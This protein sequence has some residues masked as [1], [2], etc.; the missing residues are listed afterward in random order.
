M[1]DLELRRISVSA[2]HHGE[3]MRN[4]KGNTTFAFAVNQWLETPSR[5]GRDKGKKDHGYG[6]F[7]KK[8]WG[9]KQIEDVK[10][11]DV[12]KMIS[13]LRS[14][15]V[16]NG[17]RMS[18][19]GVNNY[20]SVYNAVMNFSV[21]ELK[22]VRNFP[23][24]SKRKE[25]RREYFPQPEVISRMHDELISMGGQ[26]TL[27]AEMLLFCWHTQLRNTNVTNLK[28]SQVSGDLSFITIESHHMKNGLP[29][30]RPLNSDARAII[31]RNIERGYALQQ[32]F[33]WL[34]PIEYVFVQD[35]GRSIGKPFG[36]SGL[37]NQQWRL[38]RERAGIPSEFVFHS[39]RHGAAST[40]RREGVSLPVISTLMGHSDMKSTL[41][42]QHVT[43]NESREASDITA[44]FSI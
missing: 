33:S 7:F 31:E 18:E 24:W 43:S 26:N 36:R 39:I 38:A 44:S 29:F 21:N 12:D 19:G 30:E 17:R 8:A 11:R 14:K 3:V 13:S 10:E 40:L 27:R 22:I 37:V 41:I 20:A 5:N 28:I 15:T 1:I 42:Y 34:D 6:E 23:K 4:R 16:K 35:A 2:N 25:R 9:N 32:K